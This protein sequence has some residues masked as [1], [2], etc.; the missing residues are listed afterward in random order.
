MSEGDVVH[1]EVLIHA[2]AETVFA[3]LTDAASTSAAPSSA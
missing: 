2:S 3:F 1:R